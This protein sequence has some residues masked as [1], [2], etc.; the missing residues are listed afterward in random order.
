M[1]QHPLIKAEHDNLLIQFPGRALI[2]L[3][4][5]A[6]LFRISRRLASQHLHRRG[7]PYTKIGRI[8]YVNLTDLATYLAQCK[9]GVNTPKIMSSINYKEEMKR[10]RGFSQAAEKRQLGL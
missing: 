10:R 6:E 3:D 5:Y 8:V 9:Q 4:E 1:A 2:N 7:I